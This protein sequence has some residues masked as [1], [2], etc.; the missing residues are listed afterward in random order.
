[1]TPRSSTMVIA[2]I[3]LAP[4]T[5]LA[6]P[7]AVP[8]LGIQL[9][10]PAEAGRLQVAERPA[11]YEASVRIGSVVLIVYRDDEAA[12]EGSAVT[13]SRYQK[14]LRNRFGDDPV[15]KGRDAT[16]TVGGLDAWTLMRSGRL[17]ALPILD[18]RCNTYVLADRHLYRFIVDLL[19]SDRRQFDAVVK[20]LSDAK[21]GPIQRRPLPEP[22][23]ATAGK[24]PRFVSGGQ[25]ELYPDIARRLSEQGVVDFEFSIDARG[26][27]RDLKEVYA[28]SPDLGRNIPGFLQQGVYRIPADWEQAGSD[29]RR[30]TMEFQ[31]ALA[32][33]G[34]ACPDQSAPAR[35][36]DATVVR[37]CSGRIPQPNREERP[38]QAR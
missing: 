38:S 23:S 21:F 7:V 22:V 6:E 16:G 25:T 19:G 24:M 30:F 15:F 27:V 35:V 28:D 10:L 17:G 8:E 34:S 3:L 4:L 18:Y 2:A 13:D 14:Y 29:K 1:M 32:A 12:A 33:R 20:S 37:V 11:G 5:G 9:E 31:F 36:P 26:H